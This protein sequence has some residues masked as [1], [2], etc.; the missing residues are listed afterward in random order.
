M[1]NSISMISV[2]SIRVL[3]Y[4]LTTL[5]ISNILSSATFPSQQ[6]NDTEIGPDNTCPC[7]NESITL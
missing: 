1:I 2:G 6:Q 3:Y 4:K 7:R 5:H